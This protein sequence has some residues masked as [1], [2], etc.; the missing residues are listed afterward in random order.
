MKNKHILL[1]VFCLLIAIPLPVV[2]VNNENY[3]ISFALSNSN[4]TKII[5]TEKIDGL[6]SIKSAICP[7]GQLVKVRF[8]EDQ[9]EGEKYNHRQSIYHFREMPGAL[10]E[11]VSDP[12]KNLGVCVLTDLNFLNQIELLKLV[13]MDYSIL[14]MKNVKQVEESRKREIDRSWVLAKINDEL[15]IGIVLFKSNETGAL[16]SLVLI[17]G[18]RLYYNDFPKTIDLGYDSWRVDDD[19]K[20]GGKNFSILFAYKK[21]EKISIAYSWVGFEGN[22][23]SIIETEDRSFREIKDGYHYHAAM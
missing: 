23:L 15:L 6:S 14:G 11:V 22:S 3:N 7:G 10:F 19:G 2:G 5:A 13:K 17:R 8:V 21:N 18:D 4:G 9:K 16:A 1:G 20:L 12:I